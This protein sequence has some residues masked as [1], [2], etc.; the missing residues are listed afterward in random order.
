MLAIHERKVC[1]LIA[2][3]N[4]FIPNA[5]PT[6]SFVIDSYFK[7]WNT[8]YVSMNND[9]EPILEGVTVRWGVNVGRL[10]SIKLQGWPP[11][12]TFISTG[13]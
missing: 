9:T 10:T 12:T 2:V 1:K 6:R 13:G 4:L 8:K 7:A 5:S 3:P 11:F